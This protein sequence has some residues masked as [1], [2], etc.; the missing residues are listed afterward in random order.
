M[1]TTRLAEVWRGTKGLCDREA[2]T[3]TGIEKEEAQA[4][5]RRGELGE[6]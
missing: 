2:E 1:E 3:I 5:V 6:R 4:A